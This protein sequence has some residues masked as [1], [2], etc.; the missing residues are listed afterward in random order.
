[1]VYDSLSDFTSTP[2]SVCINDNY[3][4]NDLLSSSTDCPT[5][6][7]PQ[8]GTPSTT[9]LVLHHQLEKVVMQE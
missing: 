6:L 4:P 5:K 1:M 3:T 2:G 9:S 8:D 7:L